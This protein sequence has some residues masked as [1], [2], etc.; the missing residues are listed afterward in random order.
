VSTI[1]GT[2][3]HIPQVGPGQYA[4]A[5][6][7]P[8]DVRYFDSRLVESI[9]FIEG[10]ST[11]MLSKYVF[12]MGLSCVCV[13]IG[14]ATDLFTADTD[15]VRSAEQSGNQEA[16]YAQDAL[17]LSKDPAIQEVA[18]RIA[19]DGRVVNQR[20]ATLAIE[21]GWPSPTLNPPDSI[22]HYSDQRYLA[23]EIRLQRDALAFYTEEAANGADA[24]LQKFARSRVPILR[25]RLATLRAVRTS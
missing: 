1:I 24:A 7:P 13:T 10:A 16:A 23:H 22:S 25:Q 11:V 3:N 5:R 12:M 9:K 2:I 20:S 8:A 17:A 4:T 19:E 15:F 21:K 14:R 18:K 6:T